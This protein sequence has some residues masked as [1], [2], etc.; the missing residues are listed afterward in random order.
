MVSYQCISSCLSHLHVDKS[1]YVVFVV[2]SEF[3]E[4]RV[5]ASA[6]VLFAAFLLGGC[7]E[8][9]YNGRRTWSPSL[10]SWQGCIFVCW[11]GGKQR[12]LQLVLSLCFR[13]LIID[14]LW[15]ISALPFRD[16]F[17]RYIPNYNILL[18]SW[19]IRLFLLAAVTT[20]THYTDV[21]SSIHKLLRCLCVSTCLLPVSFLNLLTAPLF[22]LTLA[23]LRRSNQAIGCHARRETQEGCQRP[24]DPFNTARESCRRC[25]CALPVP[26]T[27]IAG[28]VMNSEPFLTLIIFWF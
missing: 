1:S 10:G 28:I 8:S 17:T 26:S 18:V 22:S 9:L 21:Y 24:C 4:D 11:N 2:V 6:H 19:V 25:L 20:T 27:E 23:D 14:R 15:P 16:R 13:L 12:F 5:Q 3:D 7:F